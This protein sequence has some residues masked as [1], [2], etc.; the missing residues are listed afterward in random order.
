[1]SKAAKAVAR[2]FTLIELMVV[3]VIL[4]ALVALVGPNVWRALAGSTR[5]TVE[6]QIDNFQKAVNLY[7]LDKRALPSSLED[8]AQSSSASDEPYIAKIPNDPWD[9]PYEYQIVNAGKRDY[10]I[11][12]H[13]EDKQAGTDDDIYW[14]SI[15]GFRK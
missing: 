3:I 8:L 12:S 6:V 2:G 11:S 9:E 4:G 1:M 15:E 14:D 5:K 10:S 13:G 7:Y